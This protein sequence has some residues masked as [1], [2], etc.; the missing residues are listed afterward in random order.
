[1]HD[2]KTRMGHAWVEIHRMYW[3]PIFNRVFLKEDYTATYEAKIEY[4]YTPYEAAKLLLKHNHWG[5][6]GEMFVEDA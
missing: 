5:P 2:G 4:Q 6:W 1:M 3:D